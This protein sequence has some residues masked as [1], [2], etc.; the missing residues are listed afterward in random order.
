MEGVEVLVKEFT[1]EDLKETRT[2][3]FP[4]CKWVPRPVITMT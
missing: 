4:M 3:K 1:E 2:M